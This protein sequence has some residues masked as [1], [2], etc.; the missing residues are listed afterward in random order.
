[1]FC[2]CASI[3]KVKYQQRENNELSVE[4]I[5][6]LSEEI[7]AKQLGINMDR[8]NYLKTLGSIEMLFFLKQQKYDLNDTNVEI[9][10]KNQ[11]TP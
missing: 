7:T 11:K 5:M 6:K 9:F 8:Y 2:C 1:M 4:E 3:K 10:L